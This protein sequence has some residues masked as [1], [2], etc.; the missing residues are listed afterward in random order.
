M[1]IQTCCVVITELNNY[2]SQ[3]VA[4]IVQNCIV[5]IDCYHLENM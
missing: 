3:F 2:D 5:G 1:A 4:E